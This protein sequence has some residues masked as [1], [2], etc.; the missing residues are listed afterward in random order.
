[1]PFWR[2]VRL[3]SQAHPRLFRQFHRRSSEKSSQ[4]KFGQ[5]DFQRA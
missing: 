3:P 5:F 1:M 4:A 2:P